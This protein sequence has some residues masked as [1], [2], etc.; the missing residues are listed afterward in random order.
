MTGRIQELGA[1]TEPSWLI[2]QSPR[3]SLQSPPVRGELDRALN[4]L[5]A[6]LLQMLGL[7]R[8]LSGKETACVA[9]DTGN[10][11]LT[12]GLGRPPGKG[13]G[14]PLQCSCLENPMARG[15]W[16]ATVHGVAE[17]WR[18]LSCTSTHCRCY[19]Q[20]KYPFPLLFK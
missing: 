8:W 17:S 6:V 20:N 1:K 5:W 13:H 18:Q 3:M 4:A 14:N 19:F 9:G 7:P 2:T 11:G 10:M 16:R 12:S 15:A